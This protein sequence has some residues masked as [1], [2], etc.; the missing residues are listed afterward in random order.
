A[1]V[2]VQFAVAAGSAASPVNWED[3][4]VLYF[5]SPEVRTN[6]QRE[7]QSNDAARSSAVGIDDRNWVY[8][9]QH[10]STGAISANPFSFTIQI[11]DATWGVLTN[12]DDYSYQA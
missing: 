6:L 11:H 3:I 2:V 9:W 10:S 7:Y 1:M 4:A 12:A 5:F 8:V